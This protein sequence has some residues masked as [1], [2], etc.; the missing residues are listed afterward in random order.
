MTAKPK[1]Q[2]KTKH[3]GSG[4]ILIIAIVVLTVFAY[5]MI[6][7]LMRFFD[8]N[9]EGWHGI[10]YLLGAAVILEA[11]FIIIGYRGKAL[12]LALLTIFV[13]LGCI[14]MYINFDLVWDSMVTTL[15]LWPTIL[16]VLFGTVGLWIII[17]LIL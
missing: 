11:W 7:S 16:I 2:T 10:I 5:L 12:L 1:T 8:R 17:K 6:P 14:W 15:G 3:K 13:T 9:L 4:T